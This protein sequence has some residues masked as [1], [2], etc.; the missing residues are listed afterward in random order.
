MATNPKI[1]LLFH[2]QQFIVYSPKTEHSLTHSHS[3]DYRWVGH[4]FET[5]FIGVS[6]CPSAWEI[7]A[8]GGAVFH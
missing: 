4:G 8:A 6:V 5:A 2:D 1:R 3:A 7:L